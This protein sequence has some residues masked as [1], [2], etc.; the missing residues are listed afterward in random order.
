MAMQL[1]LKGEILGHEA[2]VTAPGSSSLSARCLWFNLLSE[3]LPR[4]V[5]ANLGLAQMLLGRSGGNEFLLV[6]PDEARASAEA[7][8]A[9]AAFG[10]GATTGGRLRLIW[11]LTENLGEWP[12]VEK[13]LA[14]ELHTRR[15]TAGLNAISSIAD[16]AIAALEANLFASSSVIW[17][18]AF[19]G[20]LFAAIENAP[21]GPCFEIGDQPGAII[22]TRQSA[23]SDSGNG[24]AT[25]GELAA[26]ATGVKR[27]A[28]LRASVDEVPARL[29][30]AQSV[31]DY[32]GLALALKQFQQGELRLLA[33]LPEY[34]RRVTLIDS[35]L[36]E[37]ALAGSWD[38]LILFAREYQR[39][40]QRFVEEQWGDLAGRDGKTITMAIAVAGAGSINDD[41]NSPA[42]D[43]SSA[44]AGLIFTLYR[45][46]GDL[47]EQA[48]TSDRNSFHLL[49]RA[50][51]WKQLNRSVE[52]KNTMLSL[53]RD[54]GCSEEFLHD[55]SAFF[56]DRFAAPGR[57]RTD[58]PWRYYRRISAALGE[59]AVSTPGSN[60]QAFEKQ[61]TAL[62][63]ELI[64][65]GSAQA[66]LRPSGR[67]AVDWARL[68]LNA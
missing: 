17:N 42:G 53:V 32:L 9:N 59:P 41:A 15:G 48:K 14:D 24:P 52:L 63:N 28:V 5:L 27:A 20:C 65:R 33:S 60:P 47:L 3:V 26:R 13:R 61:K 31:E 2:F 64:G 50:I 45:E 21:Q 49:G 16:D 12:L 54:H 58:R 4:A 29:Q 36:G 57:E 6:L 25:L 7:F 19:S 23:L 39:L 46:A 10:I 22:L 35:G 37:F 44:S 1:F 8:L 55:L 62:I 51:D 43:D 68:E 38:A 40:F 67:V 18:P 11:A 56:A 34:F 66:R 30:R